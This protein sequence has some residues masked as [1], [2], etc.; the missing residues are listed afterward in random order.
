MLVRK[1]KE[2]KVIRV[3]RNQDTVSKTSTENLFEDVD[4]EFKLKS[5]AELFPN[6]DFEKIKNLIL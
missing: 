6:E 2:Y 4:L 3:F 1:K 5:V